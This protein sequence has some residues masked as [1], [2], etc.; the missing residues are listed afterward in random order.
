VPD[1]KDEF[2]GVIKPTAQESTPWWPESPKAPEGAPNVVFV[3]LDDVGF[4]QLGCYGSDIATPNMDRLAAG[5]LLYNNF[6]TTALCSPTR[7]CL[8]TGRNHHSVGVATVMELAS[9]YPGY[10]GIIPKSAGT[11]AE[12]LKRSGYNTFAA[13]KWH[14][15]PDGETSPAGPYDRWPLGM[16]FERF[17]GFLNG[18]T[19]QWY[20][21]LTYDN[22]KV[23]QPRQ[24]EDGYHLT[25]DLVDRAIGF[26][27]DQQAAA[28]EKPFFL[29]LSFGACHA[30]HHAPREFID[31]YKGRFDMGWDIAREETLARQK[32]KGLVPPD[33]E[34]PPRNPGV[35]AWEEL[36]SDEQRLFA[37]MMEI[38]AGFMEHTDH[39]LGR[40]LDFLDKLGCMDDTLII[41]L[42]DNG[43]SMEGGELGLSNELR[44]FNVAPES[45]EELLER[46]DDLGGTGTYNHYPFGWAM[47]GNTPLKR[48]KQ[49]THGGGIR[50]PL[51]IHWPAG[52][53]DKGVIRTQY[54]HV[55]DIVPTVLEII[56]IK[57]PAELDGIA[58]KPMEGVSM[59]YSLE[60]GE[61]S[62][63]KEVQY[64]E[65]LGHRGI[66]QKGWKAVTWHAAWASAM[67][68]P[69]YEGPVNDGD[70]DADRWELYHIDEDFSECRDLAEEHPEKLQELKDLW[71]TEAE[72]HD[73]L[74]L[75][76]RAPERY[77][78]PKPKPGG[79]RDTYILYPGTSLPETAA[80]DVRNRSHSITAEVNIPEGG[81]EGVLAAMAGLTAGYVLYIQKNHLVYEHNYLD[82]ERYIITSESEV[83][84]GS[85]T[86]RFEFTKTGE[87]QG[88]GALFINGEKVGEGDIPHTVPIR[89]SAGEGLDIGR[90]GT[91]PV[92]ESYTCPYAFTG[93]LERV[94]FELDG[95][96]HQDPEG[97]FHAA[98]GR[99]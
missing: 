78:A 63:R 37:R 88:T 31:K 74:P 76:D 42:S 35:K 98:M 92:S 43:A 22:H 49:H 48:Y 51:I 93:T 57:P 20:P 9:G 53:K 11:I 68:V 26:V 84:E 34:L 16:G 94:V 36:S 45:L 64:F 10:D 44:F 81:A 50:D 29:L 77:F 86:L 18:D 25:E 80:P 19:N 75:D 3:V 30:P 58:Q 97:D 39:H 17:Y 89:F 91:T 46:M 56:G 12:I 72:K 52:I 71:W 83:P 90:D 67:T 32:E 96:P 60:D 61:A 95:K 15:T 55:V 1:L 6:H 69:G 59:A 73:V 2:K 66:W 4:S 87:H 79:E 70:Y 23:E 28:P 5:G 82:K 7:A 65:M 62:T 33:T 99:Q 85:S 38:Y 24:P 14:L 47:A 40:F 8:L 54:H 41:F 21:D 13:G 27:R